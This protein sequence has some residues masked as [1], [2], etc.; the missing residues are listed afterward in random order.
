[1]A[2]RSTR[3]QWGPAMAERYQMISPLNH[4]SFGMVSLARDSFTGQCVAL[5]CLAKLTPDPTHGNLRSSHDQPDELAIHTRLGGHSNIVQLLN[6]FETTTH[7][8]LVLEFCPMGDLYDAI[9]AQRGPLKTEYVR[10]FMLQLVDAVSYMH[11]R[12]VYHRDIK[13]ENIFLGRKGDLKLGDFGLAT[14]MQFAHDSCV[15][16]DRYMAPEQYDSE[17]AGYEPERVDI[18]AIGIC[19]LNILFSRN[20]FSRPSVSDPLFADY[21]RDRQ[22][23]FDIF[24]AMS[25]STYEV[26]SHCLDLDPRNR[27]LTRVRDALERVDVFTVEGEIY[28]DLAIESKEVQPSPTNRRPLR[29]PSVRI[30]DALRSP[31]LRSKPIIGDLDRLNNPVH[32][33]SLYGAASADRCGKLT[34]PAGHDISSEIDLAPSLSSGLDSNFGSSYKSLV[35]DYDF[36]K[37]LG[38]TTAPLPIMTGINAEQG[39]DLEIG[40]VPKS[41]SDIWDE[42]NEDTMMAGI[43]P[44]SYPPPFHPGEVQNIGFNLSKPRSLDCLRERAALVSSPNRRRV[45]HRTP[46][47]TLRLEN[48][49]ENAQG[50]TLESNQ[51]SPVPSALHSHLQTRQTSMTNADLMA[52]WADLGN[53]RRATNER[54]GH[55]DARYGLDGVLFDEGMV[56]S[57][58][59]VWE[60]S[61]LLEQGVKGT[62][63]AEATTPYDEAGWE[64]DYE[65]I[66]GWHDLHL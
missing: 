7:K 21:V 59:G 26:L 18:W 45:A 12:H 39:R 63:E 50:P 33:D 19:L 1:M 47:K 30:S 41:W 4:G 44:A 8:W 13:P 15:G 58:R 65:W 34:K 40:G 42:E 48:R 35:L 32:P 3:E 22:S 14:T 29:T 55:P 66:G 54:M 24:P 62:N 11:S 43:E 64:Q 16:S 9:Q 61:E 60:Q 17:G 23:L 28:D 53:K 31:S 49:R 52:K 25:E 51:K 6:S 20:P 37:R 36:A 10:R 5:K 38:K 27:S 56:L 2:F 57:Q 46:R